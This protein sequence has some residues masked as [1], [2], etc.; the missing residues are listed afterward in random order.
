[1][2]EVA[3]QS[4][5]DPSS[6][7]PDSKMSSPTPSETVS[8]SASSASSTC[9]SSDNEMES[10]HSHVQ[11]SS[12]NT[13]CSL[14]QETYTI[15]KVLSCFHTFCQPCLEKTLETGD[16]VIC[17]TCHTDT[18]L[19]SSGV[20]GLLPDF[21]I[22]NILAAN[23]TDS[24]A[25]SCTGCKSKET[26]AVARCFD[27]A[28]FLCANCVM[29]HQFMHC[30]EGHRVM[31]LGELQNNKEDLK[32]E[33]PVNCSKH[34]SE[35]VR[36]FC[37]TCDMPICKDCTML[38]HSR[39]HEYDY[40]SEISGRE[41][42]GL[43]QLADQA[44]VKA[45]DLR[46]S[47]K[48]I[49]HSS[50]RLQIAYH[51][52]QTEI[53]ETYNFYRTM[54]EERKLEA[55]KELDSAYNAKQVLLSTVAQKMQDSIEKLYQ[56]C[57]FLEKILK[58]ASHT[59]ILMFKKMSDTK[60]HNLLNYSPEINMQNAF[61]IEFVSNY[62]AIQVGVRNT[63]GYVRQSPDLGSCK[64]DPIARPNG[65]IHPAPT[66]TTTA[67]PAITNG[68]TNGLS[69]GFSNGNLFDPSNLLEVK[70]EFPSN[71][72]L[73]SLTTN[74]DCLMSTG[75]NPYEKWSNGGLD[76]F[77]SGDIFSMPS[78]P[79]MDITSKL[80]T[81]NIYPPKSQIKRQKMIYHCKFGEYGALEC[82]FTEPSG[83]A[84]NA[85][86][87]IIVADTNNHRIQIFDKE[88][89]FKF[90]FG[91]CGKRDGQL[92]YPNRVAVVKSSGDIVVTERSPTHQVCR[93]SSEHSVL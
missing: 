82:Q 42:Q 93:V 27:C 24:N 89:R 8:S 78:D 65:F 51:K 60:L 79:M 87:D 32:V 6:S 35:M 77:Q 45:N 2:P 49:E 3:L 73:T 29:A 39:G 69:H 71:S 11:Q 59:E 76:I 12:V 74:T 81:A 64:Q 68:F 80:I 33:K 5:T 37:K 61:D 55:L 52:A 43:Q 31:T 36:F 56:G 84:V 17:P 30:F 21:A 15:P 63:F 91:E 34:K 46:G 88:G 62:Q 23:A 67:P 66:P 38:E 90:Q 48:N 20:A 54:L 70:E 41:V 53:T 25:L 10:V 85:Q 40:L 28:N 26:N 14:C 7:L 1:M 13:K 9:N 47:A 86:N 75:S 22:S 50:N 72:S 58:H 16:K 4:F 44:K 18:F 19:S 83:V 57:D 92:L